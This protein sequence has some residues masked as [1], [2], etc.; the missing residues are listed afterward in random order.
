MLRQACF[1]EKWPRDTQWLGYM[2]EFGI[3]QVSLQ[4]HLND[5][6]MESVIT[7]FSVLLV[8]ESFS[9]QQA[10]IIATFQTELVKWPR[11]DLQTQCV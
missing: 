11:Q 1:D 5:L 3:K 9:I 6:A 8:P 4:S 2:A 10:Q 7:R